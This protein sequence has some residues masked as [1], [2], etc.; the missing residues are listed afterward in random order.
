MARQKNNFHFLPVIEGQKSR[1]LHRD[2]EVSQKNFD[3]AQKYIAANEGPIMT[4]AKM[5]DI[6][7]NLFDYAYPHSWLFKNIAL[8]MKDSKNYDLSRLRMKASK[9][10]H[11]RKSKR[12]EAPA[13][14]AVEAPATLAIEGPATEAVA[15]LEA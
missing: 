9:P 3:I 2:F 12:I 13:T 7:H 6:A 4:R 11:V 15:T 8:R 5:T 10:L 14:E 1:S